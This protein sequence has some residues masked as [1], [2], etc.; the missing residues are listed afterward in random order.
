MNLNLEIFDHFWTNFYILYQS[1]GFWEFFG[2]SL[3]IFISLCSSVN[4]LQPL[5]TAPPQKPLRWFVILCYD[6]TC[7]STL[8][9]YANNKQKNSIS[10][11]IFDGSIVIK[12]YKASGYTVYLSVNTILRIT[13]CVE[14]PKWRPS[15]L[16]I[17]AL[18]LG[19]SGKGI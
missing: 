1:P 10:L 7:G 2:N 8:H 15:S 13:L 12:E 3:I 14:L 17:W 16:V 9:L 4:S 19:E 18:L 5:Y 6:F 11:T